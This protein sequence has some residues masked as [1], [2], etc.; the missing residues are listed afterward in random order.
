[1]STNSQTTNS[2]TADKASGNPGQMTLPENGIHGTTPEHLSPKE[3]PMSTK[4]LKDPA[5]LEQRKQ[6]LIAQFSIRPLDKEAFQRLEDA[7]WAD[8]DPDVMALYSGEFVVPYQR[9]VVAHGTDVAA[10]LAEAARVTGLP[11]DDLPLVGITDP[12][13]DMPR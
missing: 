8:Q 4:L 5:Y 12:L 1:M 7:R 2:L 9:Q 11:V 13:L 3:N 6:A 10:V